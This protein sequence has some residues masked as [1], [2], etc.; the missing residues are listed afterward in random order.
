M[1]IYIVKKKASVSQSWGQR[2]FPAPAKV[3][4]PLPKDLQ[5]R[6]ALPWHWNNTHSVEMS[7]HG[8]GQASP[9]SLQGCTESHNLIA[10]IHRN[11]FP[12]YILK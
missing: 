11:K 6:K 12:L 1:F 7:V 2:T 3:E 9:A 5:D 10:F 4:F 8:T